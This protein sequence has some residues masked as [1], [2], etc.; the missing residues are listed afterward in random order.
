MDL[1]RRDVTRATNSNFE[2]VLSFYG[3]ME[4]I[5]EETV[6]AKFSGTLRYQP[7]A[8]RELKRFRMPRECPDSVLDQ[9]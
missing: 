8:F 4:D 6:N 1:F 3:K 7:C 2:N 9:P 5:P